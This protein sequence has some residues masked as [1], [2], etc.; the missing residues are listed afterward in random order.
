MKRLLSWHLL[1]LLMIAVSS[2]VGLVLFSNIHVEGSLTMILLVVVSLA[3]GFLVSTC[4]FLFDYLRKRIIID[5]LTGLYNTN[6]L[7]TCKYKEIATADRHQSKLGLMLV[8]I[9]GMKRLRKNYS[10]RSVKLIVKEVA[11]ILTKSSRIGESIFYLNKGQYLIFYNDMKE[12]SNIKVIKERL[13]KA[14][15]EPIH[16]RG[17]RIKVILEFGFG[18]YPDDGNTFENVLNVTKQRIYLEKKR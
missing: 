14:F 18:V 4:I 6:Y 12:Y 15:E 7:S 11:R 17:N 8:E 13:H 2:L 3:T 16:I 9:H 5:E 10:R 1:L